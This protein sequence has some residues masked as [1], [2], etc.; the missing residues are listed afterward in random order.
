[1]NIKNYTYEASY[2]CWTGTPESALGLK[3]VKPPKKMKLGTE[4]IL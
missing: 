2:H 3:V 4:V 1:M